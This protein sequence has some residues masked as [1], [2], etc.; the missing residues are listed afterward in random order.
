MLEASK[1]VAKFIQN[2]GYDLAAKSDYKFVEA[3]F[4]ILVYL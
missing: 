3:V 4:E 1:R 2:N